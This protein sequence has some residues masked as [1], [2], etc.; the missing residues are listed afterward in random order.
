MAFGIVQ[1]V[2]LDSRGAAVRDGDLV[3]D[4]QTFNA[5]VNRSA[6]AVSSLGAAAGT[7]AVV[8]AKNSYLTLTIHLGLLHAGIAAVPTSFHLTAYELAHIVADS[9]AKLVFSDAYSVAVAVEAVALSGTGATI[10]HAEDGVD[11]TVDWSAITAAA[12]A[13][14]PDPTGR[15]HL[16][17]LYTSGTTGLP[18]AVTVAQG[19]VS[20]QSVGDYITGLAA[21]PF[22][23]H[24]PHLVVG[25]MYHTGPLNGVWAAAA[26][27]PVVLM[28]RFDPEQV[29]AAIDR[30]EIGS[31]VMVPTHF[32]RL[33]ALD[34][35]IKRGYELGSL[36]FVSHTGAPCP[37]WLKRTMIDWW[38]PVIVEAYGGTESGTVTRIS[39]AEWLERPGSVGRPIPPFA[40]MFAVDPRGGRLPAGSVGTL[41]VVDGTGRGISYYKDAE[42]TKTAHIA[43]GVFTLGD[44][45]YVDADGYVFVTDRATDMVVSGGVNIYPAEAEAVLGQ[46]PSVEDVAV[47]GLPDDEM[48]EVVVALVVQ[49][50]EQITEQELIEFCRANLSHVKCPRQLY[51]RSTLDRTP[52]GKVNKRMLKETFLKPVVSECGATSP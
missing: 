52:M 39:S 3:I 38:G 49:A 25:P 1:N 4:W 35:D 20:R 16:P 41:Y 6:N 27:V 42:K 32:Y 10:I 28:R 11:G 14:E 34:D 47:I 46:H 24:G 17:M 5:D 33:H 23:H 31:S 37:P 9:E 7:R 22:T 8:M 43:P 12:S 30:Y 21:N 50:D 40:D 29:L 36:Q 15:H 44:V 45:G 48:G 26:G 2:S 19:E 13:S 51:F 18:K